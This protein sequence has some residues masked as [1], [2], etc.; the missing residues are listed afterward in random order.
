MSLLL[1]AVL[2]FPLAPFG[3]EPGRYHLERVP[4]RGTTAFSKV[5]FAGLGPDGTAFGAIENPAVQEPKPVVWAPGAPC[6]PIPLPIPGSLFTGGISDVNGWGAAVGSMS[7]PSTSL[8]TRAT[9]WYGNQVFLLPQVGDPNGPNTALGVSDSGIVFGTAQGVSG[10][11]GPTLAFWDLVT[12]AVFHEP[13]VKGPRAWNT[14]MQVL[15]WGRRYVGPFGSQ[16]GPP[17]IYENGLLTELA[18]DPAYPEFHG[19]AIDEG[20]NVAGYGL[21]PRVAGQPGRRHALVWDANGL[22]VLG[23]GGRDSAQANGVNQAGDVV[24]SANFDWLP[25]TAV[26]WRGG[27]VYDLQSRVCGIGSG[28][29]VSAGPIFDS[30]RITVLLDTNGVYETAWLVP[31][32]TAHRG[33]ALSAGLS[34]RR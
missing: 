28:R 25:P 8:P 3:D 32:S 17:Q 11:G 27:K 12:G 2:F 9:L 5:Y 16:L 20:G 33:C 23:T 6:C 26:L 15:V 7:D 29:L 19:T 34:H 30:G 14:S 13:L 21:L 4:Y 22:N 31:Q 10:M 1:S 18:S 24:G